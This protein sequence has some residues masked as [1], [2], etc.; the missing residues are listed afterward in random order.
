MV[1]DIVKIAKGHTE[2]YEPNVTEEIIKLAASAKGGK[3][4]SGTWTPPPPPPPFSMS[5]PPPAAT[6]PP[7][8]AKPS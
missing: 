1:A 5:G 7:A 3:I 2:G 4:A 8:P 6:T